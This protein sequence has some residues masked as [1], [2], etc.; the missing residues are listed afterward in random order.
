MILIIN[1]QKSNFNILYAYSKLFPHLI[2]IRKTLGKISPK[3]SDIR[4]TINLKL[5]T[6]HILF[7][8]LYYLGFY[9]FGLQNCISTHA[10]G[11]NRCYGTLQTLTF[12][13]NLDFSVT[14]QHSYWVVIYSW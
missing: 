13:Q 3:Q 10:H 7:L 14:H 4:T 8:F 11:I 2:D 9:L 1:K 6:S 12:R 5:R